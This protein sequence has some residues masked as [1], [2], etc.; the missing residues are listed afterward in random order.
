MKIL[1]LLIYMSVQGQVAVP[2][3][4]MEV[5][6]YQ[7]LRS[8][9]SPEDASV[10]IWGLNRGTNIWTSYRGQLY[11]WDFDKGIVKEIPI[12]KIEFHKKEVV[13]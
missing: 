9:G 3:L 10:V 11:E 5:K 7:E 4:G 8:V 1:I 13:E 12:P 2:M 6:P